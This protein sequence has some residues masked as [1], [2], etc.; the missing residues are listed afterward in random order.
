MT[1]SATA[2]VAATPQEVLE[3]VL[4]LHRY[5][6]VD[7]KIVR[8]VSVAGPNGEGQGSV[9]MW[10]RMRWMPPAPDRQDF[11]LERWNRV[12]FTGAARQPARM[13]FD[14]TGT[15]ECQDCEAGSELTHA[16][17][18]RFKGPFRWVERVLK[19]WLQRQIEEEVDAIA[20]RFGS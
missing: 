15:V 1:A 6:E 7:P 3:F 9:K 19:S 8:V 12:T 13:I 5:K 18:F 2:E 10:A 16:Y 11:V 14:F 17:E 20:K 4:D